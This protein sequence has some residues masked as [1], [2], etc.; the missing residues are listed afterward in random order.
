LLMPPQWFTLLRELRSPSTLIDGHLLNP[1]IVS[2]DHRWKK[3]EQ[4]SSM[5]N[6]FTFELETLIF[7]AITSH[8]CESTGS[9]GKV[10][11]FGDDIICE[12]RSVTAVTAALRFFGFT[13]NEDK[14]FADGHFK[15]SCGGDFWDGRPVRP[16][17]LKE[18]LDEPHKLIAAAN[19]IRRLGQDLFGSDRPFVRIH[20]AILRALPL[21]VRRCRGPKDLG[22]IVIH[23]DEASYGWTSSCHDRVWCYRPVSHRKV[24]LGTFSPGTVHALGLYGEEVSKGFINPRDSVIGYAV[25][26]VYVYGTDWLPVVHIRRFREQDPVLTCPQ[27][28]PSYDPAICRV[29]KRRVLVN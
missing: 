20:D 8:S 4:F 6:G 14:S 1:S 29:V 10:Y 11:V 16:F 5:G 25:R 17:F 7:W 3:L 23:S 27:V 26:K 2:G 15:E 13:L 21:R 22:D 28:G 19:G 18:S 24:S 12:S 9:S